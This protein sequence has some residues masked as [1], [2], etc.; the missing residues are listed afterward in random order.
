MTVATQDVTGGCL[1]GAVRFIGDARSARSARAIAACAA[2]G[3]PARS[4]RV[5]CGD[6]VKVSDAAS[7]AWY[8]SSDWAER[9][10]CKQCGSTAVLIVWSAS[11]GHFVSAE[12]FDDTSGFAFT[13]QIFIDE[14]PAYYDFA[15]KTKNMTG[16]EVFAAFAQSE[17]KANG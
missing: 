11:N 14:K 6:S 17:A 13:H 10:F 3:R 7:L 8:R 16:A 1:C 4:S 2:A 9:A 5:D 12:A 15:N